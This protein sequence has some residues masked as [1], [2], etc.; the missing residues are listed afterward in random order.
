MVVRW[1]SRPPCSYHVKLRWLRLIS[2][3][4]KRG[5]RWW[6]IC[7]DAERN[8]A[9]VII[10]RQLCWSRRKRQTQ[11]GKCWVGCVALFIY[12]TYLHR[13]CT[14][15]CPCCRVEIKNVISDWFSR[16]LCLNPNIIFTISHLYI[17]T[18]KQ[19][20]FTSINALKCTLLSNFTELVEFYIVL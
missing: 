3:P 1:W 14:S 2:A 10:T 11:D 5:R 13:S 7:T 18:C 4:D 12:F 6:R 16:N 8:V 9:E 17:S 15:L 20:Q 19:A